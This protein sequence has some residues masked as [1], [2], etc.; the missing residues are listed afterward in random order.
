MQ[1]IDL[2]Q[3]IT[4]D[5]PLFSDSAPKP[6]IGAWMS[7][8]EAAASGNYENCSCEITQVSFVS[9][10]STYLDAPYH[11]DPC[12]PT[13]D[14]MPLE[15]CVLPGVCVDARPCQ[16]RQLLSAELFD[17]VDVADKAVL[18][19]TGWSAHWGQPLYNEYPFMGLEAGEYL[20]DA[21]A[22]LVGVDTLVIDDTQDPRRPMHVT[23]LH[24]GILI[25]EN[26]TGLDALIGREF[27]FH[28]APVKV[29][30]A[31]AFPIRAYAVLA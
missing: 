8:A 9:S 16:P 7:H 26:L 25:V 28:A 13:I 27:T 29:V 18:V 2:S 21:G 3:T 11:Y 19:C 12:G 6:E 31:A 10:L 20:R 17:G 4:P 15:A 30:G 1:L 5:M 23:L 22:K 14:Q 24:V